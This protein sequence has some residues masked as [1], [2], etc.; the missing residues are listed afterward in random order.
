MAMRTAT[1]WWLAWSHLAALL[2]L[3]LSQRLLGSWEGVQSA[4]TV[5]AFVALAAVIGVRALA[6]VRTTDNRRKV[7]RTHLLAAVGTLLA[8]VLYAL[9]TKWGM[10]MVGLDDL[11]AQGAGRWQKAMWVLSAAIGAGAVLPI[12]MIEATLGTARRERFDLGSAGDHDAVEYRRVREVGL[13]G[14]TV[15]LAAGFLMVTCNV[16]QQRNLRTDVSYFKTSAPGESTQ[17]ILKNTSEPVKAL[18]FFPEINEVKDE[19]RAYFE[20]L[21]KA[22]GKVAVEAHDIVTAKAL[23]DEHKVIKDG[24]IVLVRGEGEARKMERIELDTDI[25]KAR[26]AVKTASVTRPTLR[27]L[28]GAVNAALMK[29]VREKRKAYLTVGHG[30]IND[31]DSIA[32][33]LRAKFPD[34]RATVIKTLLQRQ[35]Y[36]VKNLGLMDGLGSEI[37]DDATMVLVLGPRT[38]LLDEELA[39]LE[40]YV[41]R[42]GNVLIALDPMSDAGL[43]ALERR[44]G[45]RFDRTSLVDDKNFVAQRGPRWAVTNQLSSHASITSLSKAAANAGVLLLDAGSLEEV[46]FAEDAVVDGAEPKRTFVIRAM[47]EA[48]R[49]AN[50]DG[51]FT[52]GEKRDRWPVAAAVEGPKTTGD[53]GA[54]QAGWRAMV[55]ADVDLFVDRPTQQGGQ[56]FLETWGGPMPEDAIKWVGGEEVF[57]GEITVENDVEINLTKAQDS[58]RFLVTIVLAPMLVLVAGLLGTRRRRIAR[59]SD[60]TKPTQKQSTSKPSTKEESP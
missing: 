58:W 22:T 7:E 28:D 13:S 24:T 32:P 47:K 1:P 3:F 5:A 9:S 15:A 31:P 36:E 21:G 19:V 2:L 51:A 41:A 6:V 23:A 48:F 20:Q 59:A 57:S 10:G 30:E 11:S 4:T 14:L 26:R 16:A 54:E 33:D 55:F 50:G 56:L 45:L 17:A 34:A 44:L 27:N 8:V 38:P 52:D 12:V 42:G 53:D 35:H 46:P 43:G 37:P 25:E 49:D 18:L 40:R 39:T 29:L 60:Q